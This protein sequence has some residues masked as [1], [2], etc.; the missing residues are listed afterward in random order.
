MIAKSME[1]AVGIRGDA[2]SRES[3]QRAK[4]GRLAFQRKLL[5]Q[6]AIQI[7]MESRI[8]LNQ[9]SSACHRNRCRGRAKLQS[10]LQRNRHSG[11]DL[12]VLAVRSKAI[13]AHTE[14]I[15]VKGKIAE[16][17][18]PRAVGL[19]LS[20]EPAHGVFNGNGRARHHRAR[21]VYHRSLNGSRICGGLAMKARRGPQ[22]QKWKGKNDHTPHGR[23]HT[24]T[25]ENLV[26]MFEA[27][28]GSGR[29]GRRGSDA[30]R[31]EKGTAR[32]DQR[33]IRQN[34]CHSLNS[35][36]CCDRSG[37]RGYYV[38]GRAERACSAGDVGIRMAVRHFQ[39]SAKDNQRNRAQ[40]KEG[41]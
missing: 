10:Y 7:G 17:K 15:R 30:K 3:D 40:R 4:R 31:E 14:V 34:R 21:A 11:A 33:Q 32:A 16:L 28:L 1:Q 8:I 5:N 9:I 6:I 19:D 29:F 27:A 24:P 35:S 38:G 41:S 22:N 36:R 39:R 13:G 20:G 12:H 37:W 26:W 2:R 25:P 18:S 23:V